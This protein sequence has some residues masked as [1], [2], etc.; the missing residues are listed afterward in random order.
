MIGYYKILIKLFP[1]DIFKMSMKPLR[2]YHYN[3][4]SIF[5][6]CDVLKIVNKTNSI[7]MCKHHSYICMDVELKTDNV[8]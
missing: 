4:I 2:A 7:I 5:S 3:L 8:V 6:A 1:T